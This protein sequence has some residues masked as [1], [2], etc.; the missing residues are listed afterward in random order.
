M[1]LRKVLPGLSN[2]TARCVGASSAWASRMSQISFHNMLQKPAT[3]PTGA[4]S[5]LRVKGGR[6]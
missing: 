6:A 1:S 4:P 5:D 3:A 2:T